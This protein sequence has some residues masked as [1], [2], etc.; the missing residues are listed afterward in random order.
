M[1]GKINDDFFRR[2]V[3]PHTGAAAPEVVVGPRMGVDAAVLRFGD[4]YLVVAEDP[5]FP[6]P[7]MSPEDFGWI[8]V[9]I[10]ASDVAVMGVRPQYLTYSLL[11]PPGTPEDYIERLMKS[12]DDAA[13]ELGI[14]IVGGHTGFYSAVIVPTVGGITVWG[15]G[16]KVITPAG[17]RVGDAIIITK[18]AAVEAAAIFAGELGERLLAEGVP[19]ALVE[20]AGKRMREMSVVED[21]LLA[22]RLPGVHA[23]HDATEGGLARG[24]WE[25][26][27]ASGVGLRVERAA[28]PVP[29]DI[30]AVCRCFGLDPY[31]IIS[32]GTLIV[33]CDP[34]EK[35]A[36]LDLFRR[37]GIVAAAVGTVVPAEEGRRWVE[38]DGRERELVP[39][40]VDRF[41]EVFFAAL[42]VKSDPRPP[43]ERAAC[44]EVKR[45]AEELIAAGLIRLLPEVG[46]N[47]AYALPDAKTGEEVIAFPGRLVRAKDRAVAVGEP[48]RGGSTY[49]ARTLLVVRE[50]FP[51]ATC[52]INL[53]Y[54]P[55]VRRACL[56]LG[57]TMATMP[58]PPGYRQEGEDFYRD[59]RQLLAACKELPVIIELPD[60]IN[61]ERLFLVV[62]KDL[63]GLVATVKALIAKRSELERQ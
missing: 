16:E 43:A 62:G 7:T 11:L 53:R 33:A 24:L 19:P 39:P 45:A 10:G 47:L 4:R 48:E 29:E 23:M 41:W 6:G 49:M 38:A 56:D 20:R 31:E 18:G 22:A 51:A 58:T 36:L 61:L 15:T 32:E 25:V 8:T 27:E 2:A 5:I 21:A 12:I 59:L 28:V 60:R 14:A 26:A 17:A 40:A 37:H 30:A 63:P 44:L 35:D 50:F 13:R 42:A 34:A 57:L 9:H 3:L 1:I 46:A 52:I 55:A 54:D